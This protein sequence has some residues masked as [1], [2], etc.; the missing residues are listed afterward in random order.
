MNDVG[1]H[2]LS[3]ADSD[4]EEEEKEPM[5]CFNIKVKE[6]GELHFLLIPQAQKIF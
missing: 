3:M 6:N 2:S 5:R 4:E 1:E